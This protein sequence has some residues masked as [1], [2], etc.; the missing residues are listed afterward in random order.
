[1]GLGEDG[2]REAFCTK[3]C[4]NMTRVGDEGWHLG[5]WHCGMGRQGLPR[6]VPSVPVVI[7]AVAVWRG[8]HRRPLQTGWACLGDILFF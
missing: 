8:R 1:M 4:E 7:G 3:S 5:W 2:S 6:P